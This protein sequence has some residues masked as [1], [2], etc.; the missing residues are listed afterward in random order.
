MD[1]DSTLFH[2]FLLFIIWNELLVPSLKPI[3]VFKKKT[4]PVREI[5][6]GESLFVGRHRYSIQV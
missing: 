1:T 3:L 2:I 5:L 4:H 6:A